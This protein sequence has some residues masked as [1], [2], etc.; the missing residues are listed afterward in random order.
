MRKTQ[1]SFPQWEKTRCT[2]LAAVV[3][4]AMLGTMFTTPA[5]PGIPGLPRADS[6]YATDI[7]V[8]DAIVYDV[9][10]F[11]VVAY[12][13]PVID[14]DEVWTE[15]ITNVNI[16]KGAS[17]QTVPCFETELT[18][19]VQNVVRWRYLGSW[20]M[21][22]TVFQP[23][24][25]WRDLDT[26]DLLQRY[27]AASALSMG[28]QNDI[29][30]RDFSGPHGYPFTLGQTWTQNIQVDSSNDM[31]D[32]STPFTVTVADQLEE[33]TVPAGTFN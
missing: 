10:Y 5:V 19:D 30:E 2:L 16:T 13:L 23:G 33:V 9:N 21:E 1:I 20:N 14:S 17:G 4:L 22:I 24:Y 31:G 11:Y 3:I 15:T 32:T 18:Y 29:Y 7:N 12:Y 25:H 27:Q 28:V 8:G 6:A 26:K